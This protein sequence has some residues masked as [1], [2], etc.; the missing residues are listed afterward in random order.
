MARHIHEHRATH[1][2]RR[3]HHAKKRKGHHARHHKARIHK[4][5]GTN[6]FAQP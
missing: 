3:A 6:P 5:G 2:A 4:G 1:K